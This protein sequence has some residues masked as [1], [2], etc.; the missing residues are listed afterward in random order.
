MCE[1]EYML[2]TDTFGNKVLIRPYSKTGDADHDQWSFM[3]LNTI[4][5][6]LAEYAYLPNA[7]GK[8]QESAPLEKI[9]FIRATCRQLIGYR[10][11]LYASLDHH[12]KSNYNVEN[13]PG[14]I[15]HSKVKY[16]IIRA[17]ILFMKKKCPGRITNPEKVCPFKKS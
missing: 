4:D 16:P 5:G 14:R 11:Y 2:V 9:K 15:N 17:L 3:K 6:Q 8:L 10:L 12:P 13:F 1:I 7:P